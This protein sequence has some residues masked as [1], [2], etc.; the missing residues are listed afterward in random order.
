MRVVEGHGRD[1]VRKNKKNTH[2]VDGGKPLH[3]MWLSI[4]AQDGGGCQH[5][6]AVVVDCGCMQTCCMC[7]CCMQCRQIETKK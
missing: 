7:M 3:V 4:D 1:S 6:V 5:A 2:L